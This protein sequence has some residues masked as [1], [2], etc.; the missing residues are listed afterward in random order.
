MNLYQTSKRHEVRPLDQH[1]QQQILN[2]GQD[3]F[4]T[5][6]LKCPHVT[7][8]LK[9]IWPTNVACSNN[10]GKAKSGPQTFVTL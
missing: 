1:V 10:S 3:V 6:I 2:Y 9:Q 7:R 4:H 8:H 5:H